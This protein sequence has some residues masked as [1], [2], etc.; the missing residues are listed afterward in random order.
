MSMGSGSVEFGFAC[1]CEVLR[2]I[3]RSMVQGDV[4]S[5]TVRTCIVRWRLVRSSRVYDIQSGGV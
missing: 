4:W 2:S 5:G 3:V 1:R